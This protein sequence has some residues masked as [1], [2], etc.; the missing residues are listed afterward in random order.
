[1]SRVARSAPILSAAAVV[2]GLV[3]VGFELRQNTAMMRGG[4]LQAVSGSLV[5]WQTAIAL[6]PGAADLLFRIHRG[7]TREQ[8]T[9]TEN[10]QVFM[11]FAAFV[12]ILENTYLQHREGLV[13][14]AVFESYG[15]GYGTTQTRRFQEFWE[16][17]VGRVVR[18]DGIARPDIVGRDFAVFFEGRVQIGPGTP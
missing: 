12:Q 15:W 13:P 14:E 17:D 7:E 6:D 5:E 11:I 3:F 8:F 1:M 10:V 2:P 16:I 18:D 9:G 4:T